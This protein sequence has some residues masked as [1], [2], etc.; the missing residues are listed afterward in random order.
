MKISKKNKTHEDILEDKS[1]KYSSRM[2][3]LNDL[4][5]LFC[6]IVKF[7]GAMFMAT[8][9]NFNKINEIKPALFRYGRLTPILFDGFNGKI[10]N[11]IIYKNY[12]LEDIKKYTL[13]E[14]DCKFSICNSEII[15]MVESGNL[16]NFIK[17]LSKKILVE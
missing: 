8:T 13:F 17:E 2:L 11:E 10:I 4:L 5:E 3:I 7:H 15:D 9:N 12:S 16:G 14:N 6:G 1:L